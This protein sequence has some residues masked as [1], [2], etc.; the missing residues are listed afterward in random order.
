MQT[1]ATKLS[2]DGTMKRNK[3][4]TLI[5]LLVVIAI[6]AILIA[7]LLP[8]VQQAREAARR[9]QCKNNLKQLGL[10]LHNYHD[11]HGTFPMGVSHHRA[12]CATDPGTGYYVT[13]WEKRY[14]SWSWQA[15]IMPMIEQG[16]TYNQLGVSTQ[17][18][19]VALSNST[20]RTILQTQIPAFACP[21]DIAPKVNNWS[22]RVPRASNETTYAVASSSYVGSHH[23]N[24]LMCNNTSGTV[25]ASNFMNKAGDQ[26]F[27]GMFAHS[28]SVRMRDVLDGTSN[29]IMVGERAWQLMMPGAMPDAP[30]SANQ[31]VASGATSSTTNGGMSSVLGTGFFAINQIADGEP[32]IRNARQAF[33]SQHTGG[34]HFCLADGSVR[35]ISENIQHRPATAT[36]IDSTFEA[37]I[38]RADGQVIGEF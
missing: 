4:F 27:S 34:A 2:H 26:P 8:A 24:V 22:L 37:L 19:N 23:H 6:I 25:S 11:V 3:G 29:T 9:S 36:A 12:G 30:R 38:G 13:D 7:L 10:A 20:L 35:F 14:G 21:S 5:E 32:L 16:N 15:M 17:E 33:S 31:Y 1:T 28:S 18:A